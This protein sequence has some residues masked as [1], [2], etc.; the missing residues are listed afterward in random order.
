[1]ELVGMPKYRDIIIL[2]IT[3]CLKAFTRVVCDG[4]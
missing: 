2:N 3:S 4:N 1:M